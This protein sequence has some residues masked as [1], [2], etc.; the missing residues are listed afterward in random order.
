MNNL[1]NY[2]RKK[3]GLKSDA[4][5]ARHLGVGSPIISKIRHKKVPLS[6]ALI[7]LIH[8]KCGL[9]IKLIRALAVEEVAE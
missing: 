8:D 2:L 7:L 9:S 6:P 1:I 4:E 3:Q 5:L